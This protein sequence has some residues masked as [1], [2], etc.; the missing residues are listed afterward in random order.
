MVCEKM[1]TGQKYFV[2]NGCFIYG[3][4]VQNIFMFT[5]NMLKVIFTNLF[6]CSLQKAR[7]IPQ[8]PIMKHRGM[9]F[10]NT[11]PYLFVLGP[12]CGD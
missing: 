7:L 4:N 9:S 8:G 3:M 12:S 5:W 2:K 6:A 10:W 11:V 1:Y